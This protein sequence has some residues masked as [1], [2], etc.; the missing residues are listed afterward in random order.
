[1]SGNHKTFR[2]L[3]QPGENNITLQ[4]STRKRVSAISR[5]QC[6]INLIIQLT[7][8]NSNVWMIEGKIYIV[9]YREVYSLLTETRRQYRLQRKKKSLFSAK[10]IENIK[11][12]QQGSL[13]SKII[14]C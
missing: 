7:S 5:S 12:R 9:I 14:V 8:Y 10:T 6:R 11:R 4:P 1:M 13:P 2:D 3:G